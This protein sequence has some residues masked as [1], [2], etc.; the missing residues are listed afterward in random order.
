[1]NFETV[2]AQNIDL[3]HT[4]IVRNG[5]WNKIYFVYRAIFVCE[6]LLK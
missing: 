4:S 1:M 6:N 5:P 2:G 3:Y